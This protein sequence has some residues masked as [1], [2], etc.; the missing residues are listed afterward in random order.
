[1]VERECVCGEDGE[2]TREGKRRRPLPAAAVIRCLDFSL[3]VAFSPLSAS[4]LTASAPSV[5]LFPLLL[6]SLSPLSNPFYL[7]MPRLSLPPTVAFVSLLSSFFFLIFV[8]LNFFFLTILSLFNPL[9]HSCHSR[10]PSFPSFPVA[11]FHSL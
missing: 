11:T 3:T 7:F 8:F 10:Q 4:C 5:S 9:P 1:M 6:T 2:G